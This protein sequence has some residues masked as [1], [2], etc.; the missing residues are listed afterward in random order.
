MTKDDN[1][2]L[3]SSLP[4]EIRWQI[5][6]YLSPRRAYISI[7][8]DVGFDV[9]PRKATSIP[10]G[11]VWGKI[12]SHVRTGS[13][14][15]KRISRTPGNSGVSN[16]ALIGSDLQ[17]IY[18]GEDKEHTLRLLLILLDASHCGG[19]TFHIDRE[20][21]KD[22][23]IF[24]NYTILGEDNCNPVAGIYIKESNIMLY[25]DRPELQEMARLGIHN[26][27]GVQLYG[28]EDL[29][30]TEVSYELEP[31]DTY[32]SQAFA[33]DKAVLAVRCIINTPWRCVFNAVPPSHGSKHKES[34][35]SMVERYY[36]YYLVSQN[37]G[38]DGHIA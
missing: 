5:L 11:R 32:E 25:F 14:I 18:N 38:N 22:L 21:L 9:S 1:S 7:L 2:S 15:C 10:C 31:L 12:L 20:S 13:D 24:Q 23:S 29:L 6:D 37:R 16:L 27:K 8:S 19:T 28:N 33:T 17:Y 4:L 26:S 36:N 35:D 3:V 34:I 30:N